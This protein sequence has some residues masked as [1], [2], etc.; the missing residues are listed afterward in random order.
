MFQVDL[1]NADPKNRRWFIQLC[2]PKKTKTNPREEERLPFLPGWT[3]GEAEET[4]RSLKGI[5]TGAP[6]QSPDGS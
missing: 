5:W 2:I 6:V 1:V 3:P 4:G